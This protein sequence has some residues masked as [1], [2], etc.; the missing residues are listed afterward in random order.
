LEK[1][2]S[3]LTLDFQTNKKFCDEVALIPSKNLRNKIAGFVT[4]LVKRLSRGKVQGVSLTLQENQRDLKIEKQ[5]LLELFKNLEFLKV[6][7][8]T[9]LM[10]RTLFKTWDLGL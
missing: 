9:N 5:E 4:H 8:Y 1:Y 2:L 10:I 7:N 6:D 3:S